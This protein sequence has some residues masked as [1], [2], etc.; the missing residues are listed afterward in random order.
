MESIAGGGAL[1]FDL[2]YDDSTLDNDKIATNRAAVL[3]ALIELLETQKL[4]LVRASDQQTAP[5]PF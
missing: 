1:T 3:R 5:L 2:V 4:H